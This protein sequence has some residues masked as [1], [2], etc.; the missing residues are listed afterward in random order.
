MFYSCVIK[1]LDINFKH[2]FMNLLLINIKKI[3]FFNIIIITFEKFILTFSS[4]IKIL[5][6]NK[7]YKIEKKQISFLIYVL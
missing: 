6:A 1:Y 4:S 2:K 5:L 7:I 3:L